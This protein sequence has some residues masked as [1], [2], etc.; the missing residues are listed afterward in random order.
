MNHEF[1]FGT[2]S[3]SREYVD[4]DRLAVAGSQQSLPPMEFSQSVC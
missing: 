4:L 2:A 3:R 1:R